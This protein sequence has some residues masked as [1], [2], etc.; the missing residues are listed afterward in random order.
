MKHRQSVLPVLAVLLICA[1]PL[2][3]GEVFGDDFLELSSKFTVSTDNDVAPVDYAE[4][5]GAFEGRFKVKKGWVVNVEVELSQEEI[6]AEAI[7]TRYK[8]EDWKFQLGMFENELLL[9]DRF[10][11]KTVPFFT[12]NLVHQR[13]EYMGWYSTDRAL[14]IRAER[15]YKKGRIPLSAFAHVLFQPAGREMQVDTGAW[16]PWRGENSWAGI[17][18]A[19]YPYYIHNSWVGTESSYAE[20]HNFLFQAVLADFS[21]PVLYKADITVGNNLIDPVGFIHYPSEGEPSWFAGSDLMAAWPR[22]MGEEFVWT[23]GLNIGALINSL[24]I[25]EA[26]TFSARTGQLL[27]WDKTFYLHLELGAELPTCYSSDYGEDRELETSMEL[28][29]GVSFQIRF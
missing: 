2:A 17:S 6:E 10:S 5:E 16:Y 23:P 12:D 25:P 21:G 27:A 8:V 11:R 15:E 22:P 18:A 26:W 19:W 13:L 4:V 20:D 9:E 3:A 14:G 29:W 28:L 7:W 24:E 1:A